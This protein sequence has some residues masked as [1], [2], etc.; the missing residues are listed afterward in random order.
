MEQSIE[1]H[2]AQCLDG[3]NNLLGALRDQ[4]DQ[5]SLRNS[6]TDSA[7]RFRVWCGNIGAHKT[8][9]SSLDYRLRDSH[10]MKSRVIGFLKDLHSL[11][12]DCKDAPWLWL[13]RAR[14]CGCE[15]CC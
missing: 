13:F 2:V 8:D 14:F 3:F 11:I 15:L 4:R 12:S 5:E 10:R 6:I 9:K 7:G 1:R